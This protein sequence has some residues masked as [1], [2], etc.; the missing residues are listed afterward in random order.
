MVEKK[1]WLVIEEGEE[2]KG[3]FTLEEV[4]AQLSVLPPDARVC[5]N[6]SLSFYARDV[7][8]FEQICAGNC[9]QEDEE[10][11]SSEIYTTSQ[12]FTQHDTFHYV[13]TDN[14]APEGV[15]IFQ[16]NS[17]IVVNART[18]RRRRLRRFFSTLGGGFA[19][20]ALT[21]FPAYEISV[22]DG[23]SALTSSTRTDSGSFTELKLQAIG[24]A[25][26][27]AFS[28][29]VQAKLGR[30]NS[31]Y[32]RSLLKLEWNRQS[33]V[34]STLPSPSFVASVAMMNLPEEE[35]GK[36][37]RWKALLNKLGKDP[38]KSL[39]IVAFESARIDKV[40]R[41]IMG[42]A[43]LE[44]LLETP[45]APL[46]NFALLGIR[47]PEKGHAFKIQDENFNQVVTALRNLTE[48]FNNVAPEDKVYRNLLASRALW[49]AIQLSW[50]ATGASAKSLS[51]E[52][53][54][55]QNLALALSRP[56]KDLLISA[57][58]ERE[59]VLKGTWKSAKQALAARYRVIADAHT[60]TKILCNP[61]EST[62]VADFV[63]QTL[64]ITKFEKQKFPPQETLFQE[65]FVGSKAFFTSKPYSL[66]NTG[67]DDTLLLY[68]PR[69]TPARES[70]LA[71]QRLWSEDETFDQL[72]TR[73]I[74]GE[75]SW[76]LWAYFAEIVKVRPKVDIKAVQAKCRNNKLSSGFCA[77][78]AWHFNS[79][80][81]DRAKLM[82]IV[83]ENFSLDES[84]NLAFQVAVDFYTKRPSVQGKAGKQ[85]PQGGLPVPKSLIS[86]HPEFSSLE[87]YLQNSS[88]MAR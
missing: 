26:L 44:G 38:H 76:L 2:A 35:L 4:R 81:A 6:G 21:F 8:A 48:H 39:A 82:A 52:F 29:V 46:S 11:Q 71:H 84:A 66:D 70:V 25:S 65:C 73:G 22:E 20:L 54:S 41:K 30:D 62:I 40:F 87:W 45:G 85:P 47:K 75:G 67:T 69:V 16:N 72:S 12:L 10:I 60:D 5:R 28:Q 33:F 63:L 83:S 57:L 43:L 80:P 18:H 88:M 1:D 49:S 19:V 53:L 79:V 42:Q 9:L 15:G 77:Q 17:L 78:L 23:K 37:P 64:R 55:W 36:D 3:P 32:A 61:K 50:L 86:N 58:K 27:T 31:A 68:L 34:S 51:R 14:L 74:T 7:E 13:S 56:D 24:P 59:N